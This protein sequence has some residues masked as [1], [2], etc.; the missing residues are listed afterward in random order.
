MPCPRGVKP[1]QHT[2][3]AAEVFDGAAQGR[4]FDP[5]R[6]SRDNVGS[7]PA[8]S[9]DEVLEP[10]RATFAAILTQS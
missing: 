5:S 1:D 6:I 3:A 7:D 10:L 4:P 9:H 8:T 2:I